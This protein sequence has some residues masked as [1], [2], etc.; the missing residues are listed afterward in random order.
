VTG[1]EDVDSPYDDTPIRNIEPMTPPEPKKMERIGFPWAGE[2]EV[3]RG[4]RLATGG[5]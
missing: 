3:M 2:G 4:R 5:R 1:D